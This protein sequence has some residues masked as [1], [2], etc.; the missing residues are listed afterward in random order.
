MTH[1]HPETVLIEP[2]AALL[3]VVAGA[4]VGAVAL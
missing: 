2:F 3:F 1:S 4:G